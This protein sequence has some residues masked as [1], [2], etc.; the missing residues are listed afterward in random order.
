MRCTL[1]PSEL[2]GWESYE[3]PGITE[4]GDE[5]YE[6]EAPYVTGGLRETFVENETL[7]EAGVTFPPVS[8]LDEDVFLMASSTV[9]RRI[10]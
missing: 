5:T 6:Y 9:R 2:L 4:V 1:I 10:G 8:K 7:V 3:Y